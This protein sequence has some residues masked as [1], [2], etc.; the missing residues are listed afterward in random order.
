M[1]PGRDAEPVDLGDRDRD[2]PAAGLNGSPEPAESEERRRA[3]KLQVVRDA[4]LNAF[5]WA[6][7]RR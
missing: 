1:R 3:R 7:S 6:A 4:A 5:L 2:H